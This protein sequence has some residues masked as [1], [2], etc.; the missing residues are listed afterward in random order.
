MDGLFK[1]DA[2]VQEAN[3][4]FVTDFGLTRSSGDEPF[5]NMTCH[6]NVAMFV[7]LNVGAIKL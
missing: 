4:H 7:A 3:G 2:T 1:L 6:L 5:G